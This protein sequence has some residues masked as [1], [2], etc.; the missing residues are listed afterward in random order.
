MR[1]SERTMRLEVPSNPQVSKHG[2]GKRSQEAK[3]DRTILYNMAMKAEADIHFMAVKYITNKIIT[4][5]FD[6]R[7][8]T[9]RGK[10]VET[11]EWECP[12]CKMAKD[13]TKTQTKEHM[14]AGK[15]ITTQQT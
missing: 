12:M 5:E 10:V 6:S 11:K 3:K 9:Q 15:C 7:Q 8:N 1:K 13:T 2:Q 4:R 14:W